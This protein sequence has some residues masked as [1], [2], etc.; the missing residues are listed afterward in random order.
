MK[1]WRKKNSHFSIFPLK[2][3]FFVFFFKAKIKGRK[4][5]WSSL[6]E[7]WF[8][9]TFSL[10]FLNMEKSFRFEESKT[11]GRINKN[12]FHMNKT[13]ICQKNHWKIDTTLFF[14]PNKHNF[15]VIVLAKINMNHFSKSILFSKNIWDYSK[16][17]LFEAIFGLIPLQKYDDIFV[18]LQNLEN[19]WWEKLM[20][21]LFNFA[22]FGPFCHQIWK[23]S[24]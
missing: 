18:F 17:Y 13:Q 16:T 23:A 2:I 12:N 8:V 11:E 6:E 24:W 22:Y 5:I 15:S 19:S 1:K 14:L 20:K 21:S 9:V 7:P 10:I 3:F 4:S